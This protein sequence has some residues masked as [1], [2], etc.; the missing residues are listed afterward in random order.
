MD[1]ITEIKMQNYD[2]EVVAISLFELAGNINNALTDNQS[3]NEDVLS[4]GFGGIPDE[5]W[6]EIFSLFNSDGTIDDS[7]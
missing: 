7:R 1:D 5:I 2:D 6:D 4:D 3:Q